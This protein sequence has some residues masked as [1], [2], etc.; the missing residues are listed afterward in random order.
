MLYVYVYNLYEYVRTVQRHDCQKSKFNT[1][2]DRKFEIDRRRY[3][4]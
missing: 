1:I 2:C 3:V 4:S